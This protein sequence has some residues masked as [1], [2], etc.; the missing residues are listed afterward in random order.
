VNQQSTDTTQPRPAA[1]AFYHYC[2]EQLK[3]PLAQEDREIFSLAMKFL[4]KKAA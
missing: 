3:Q 2:Q 4:E 1:S